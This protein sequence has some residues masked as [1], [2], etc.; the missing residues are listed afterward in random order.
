MKDL[1]KVFIAFII[2][3]MFFSVGCGKSES[4]S[5]PP[6][7]LVL[8][9]TLRADHLGGWGYELETS[10]NLDAFA[11]ENT[12]IAPFYSVAPWTSPSI[13]SI[14]TSLYPSCH[15]VVSHPDLLESPEEAKGF[16]T[17]PESV[18]TLAEFFQLAGYRTVCIS[19]NPWM[20]EELGFSQGFD[21]F[22][23]LENKANAGKINEQVFKWLDE[24]GEDDRPF[25][26]YLHYMDCH[27]PYIP[28]A[29]YNEQ[30]KSELPGEY[31]MVLPKEMVPL[32]LDL[33]PDGTMTLD[34]LV[35]QYDGA[36]R[37]FDDQF[38]LLTCKLKDEELYDDSVIF[39]TSDH[40][41]EFMEHGSL[42]HGCTLY[43]EQLA[44]PLVIKMPEEEKLG[45]LKKGFIAQTIDI[46]PTL[47][48]AAGYVVPEGLSGRSL[49]GT[50]DL[51]PAFAE[52]DKK[53]SLATLIG[54]EFKYIRSID[55][56][57]A[58]LYN[59][60]MDPSEQKDLLER[61]D[62]SV[63]IKWDKQLFLRLNEARDKAVEG[64]TVQLSEEIRERLGTLGYGK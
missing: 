51:V 22:I 56:P 37:Y 10:P 43:Q 28:P 62:I 39:F 25:F 55:E 60:E 61:Q 5:G 4:P 42:D 33:I 23:V 14:F 21:D 50:L 41:E 47:V 45:Q 31:E 11:E 48:E 8:M 17:L 7:I 12:L 15:G 18:T 1:A 36:I 58:E 38:N 54:E 30:F 24:R 40:G 44:V 2:A 35:S 29:P 34:F 20:T 19:S 63:D 26:M 13:A 16:S 46:Y 64:K 59:L 27:G 57:I 53:L 52:A 6:V 49:F 9:D 3:V 32:Y